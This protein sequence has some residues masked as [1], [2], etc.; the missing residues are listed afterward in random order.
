VPKRILIADDHKS[1]LRGVRTMLETHPD[2]SVCGEAVNGYEAITKAV[3]LKPDLIVL[4]FAM[5]DLDGLQT[6]DEIRKLLPGVQI[7]LHTIY[8]ADVVLEANR[9][10]ISRV[11]QKA[12][13]EAL[14]SAVAE[15]LNPDHQG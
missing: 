1:M 3:E 2:W 13:S 4:D 15:L 10:G 9:H 5:P 12:K 8:G 11:I 7:V 6:A 14:V